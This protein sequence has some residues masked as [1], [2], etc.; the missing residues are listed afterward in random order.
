VWVD[1]SL[2][3]TIVF[4]ALKLTYA[5]NHSIL[6]GSIELTCLFREAKPWYIHCA[7]AVPEGDYRRVKWLEMIAKAAIIAN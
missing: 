5:R 3:E 7:A 6:Q 2:A 1:N 4:V